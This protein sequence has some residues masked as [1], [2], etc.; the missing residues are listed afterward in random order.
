MPHVVGALTNLAVDVGARYYGIGPGLRTLAHIAT[1]EAINAIQS[2]YTAR[3][4]HNSTV[5]TLLRAT[6]D[7]SGFVEDPTGKFALSNRVR[8][9]SIGFGGTRRRPHIKTKSLLQG[10]VGIGPKKNGKMPKR[11]GRRLF[12]PGYD[13]TVGLYGRRRSNGRTARPAAKRYGLAVNEKK[14]FDID[15][16]T[17]VF[18]GT[19]GDIIDSFLKIKQ[20][21]AENERIGRLIRV[22][23]IFMQ[24]TLLLPTTGLVAESSDLVRIII[25]IDKQTNGLAATVGDILE[26]SPTINFLSFRNLAQSRRFQIL[27]DKKYALSAGGAVGAG[28]VEK[29]I[30]WKFSKIFKTPLSIEFDDINGDLSELRTL[31]IGM[32]LI[33]ELPNKS[34]LVWKTRVRYT[35]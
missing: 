34:Q 11:N 30:P 9:L 10:R 4:A 21:T 19:T 31:N 20:G 14:F 28:S 24:G 2:G 26:P 6:P 3:E 18:P 16:T 23:S 35:D 22:H 15:N 1:N 25:Y 12:M 17:G 27:M 13:R 7:R 8:P 32:L 33:S 29:R 5:A